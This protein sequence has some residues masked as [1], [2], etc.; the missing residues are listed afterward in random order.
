MFP[1]NEII[2]DGKMAPKLLLGEV[3]VVWHVET[4]G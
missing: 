2:E 3:P 4:Y 1:K